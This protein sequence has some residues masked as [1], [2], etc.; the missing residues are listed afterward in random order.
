MKKLIAKIRRFFNCK[1]EHCKHW[2]VF[3]I[4]KKK[5]DYRALYEEQLKMTQKWEFRYNKL[6]R[7]LMLICRE[8]EERVDGNE[9]TKV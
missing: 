9:D 8:A 3:K 7:Q 2:T 4:F 1:S 5:P 6:Y